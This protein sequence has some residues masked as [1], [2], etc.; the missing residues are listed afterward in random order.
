MKI[1]IFLDGRQQGPFELSQLMDMPV[2]PTTPVW[3]EGLPQWLPAGNVAEL[4]ALFGKEP[5]HPVSPSAEAGLGVGEV[6]SGLADEAKAET[7]EEAISGADE[8]AAVEE[9]V[10]E[11]VEEKPVSKFAPGRRNYNVDRRPSEPCPST[12][13]GWSV[14]LTVCCC[15]PVSVAS[16]IASICVSS[17]YNN[18]NLEKSR[19]ASEITAWLVMIAIALG[20]LP[21]MLMGLIMGE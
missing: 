21:A 7:A 3:F 19:K 17:F 6:E 15:S 10:V 1:W 5:V 11:V 9:T 18:G 8:A 4:N 13:L 16:L 20:F 12:Y 14:F 2:E